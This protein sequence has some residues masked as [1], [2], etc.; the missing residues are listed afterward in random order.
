MSA[1]HVNGTG[2]LKPSRRHLAIARMLRV[3]PVDGLR[4]VLVSEAEFRS[5]EATY[6]LSD[7]RQ[8]V[9]A[10]TH[11][12]QGIEVVATRVFLAAQF[13]LV[14]CRVYH[15]LPATLYPHQTKSPQAVG[16][17]SDWEGV[18]V[19][20]HGKGYVLTTPRNLAHAAKDA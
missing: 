5:A 14:C 17:L 19:A 2:G 4:T 12:W 7:L 11:G 9:V 13:K 18:A 10:L 20:R 6:H 1:K 16:L 3:P 8:G 15:L